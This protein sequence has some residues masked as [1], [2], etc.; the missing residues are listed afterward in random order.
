MAPWPYTHPYQSSSPVVLTQGLI[1]RTAGIPMDAIYVAF[2][3]LAAL[4]VG[5]LVPVLLQV[6][7]TLR[8]LRIEVREARERIEPLVG[9]LEATSQ[10]TSAVTMAVAAGV[11]AF[12]TA[13]RDAE[14]HVT[15]TEA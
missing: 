5:M 10:L 12:R 8:Q 13:E 14:P 11:R 2:L 9:R 15:S 6:Y 1:P 3:T 4:L 7:V